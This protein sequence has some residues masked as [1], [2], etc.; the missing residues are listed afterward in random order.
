MVMNDDLGLRAHAMGM[1]HLLDK[2]EDT[3]KKIPRPEKII[4]RKVTCPICNN[5]F[6]SKKTINHCDKCHHTWNIS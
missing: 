4:A 1:E 6:K 2:F 3:R 5:S